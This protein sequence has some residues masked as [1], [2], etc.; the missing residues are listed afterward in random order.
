MGTIRNRQGQMFEDAQDLLIEGVA[1]GSVR[2]GQVALR[3]AGFCSVKEFGAKGDSKIADDET[4]AAALAAVI[5][6][7]ETLYIR[8]GVYRLTRSLQGELESKI[9]IGGDEDFPIVSDPRGDLANHEH[10]QFKIP[11]NDGKGGWE[12]WRRGNPEAS[13]PAVR[14]AAHQA[15]DLHFTVVSPSRSR[16]PARLTLGSRSTPSGI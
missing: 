8:R 5:S 2:L 7:G 10:Y 14:F 3:Q 6:T 1:V 16:A 4:F 11:S 12:L 15:L 9:C 13:S